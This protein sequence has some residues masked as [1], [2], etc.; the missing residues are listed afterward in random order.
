[1]DRYLGQDKR[2]VRNFVTIPTLIE[3]FLTL[4]QSS[5]YYLVL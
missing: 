5:D 2:R 4:Q 3:T 1:M